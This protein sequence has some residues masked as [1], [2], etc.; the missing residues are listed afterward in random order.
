MLKDRDENSRS[1]LQVLSSLL[2]VIQMKL[3]IYSDIQVV[4]F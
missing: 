1:V 4:D 2:A 3:L